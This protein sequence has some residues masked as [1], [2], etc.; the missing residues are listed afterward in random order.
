[1]KPFLLRRKNKLERFSPTNI[2]CECGQ[3]PAP[4]VVLPWASFLCW[5]GDNSPS[6]CTLGS[7]T[8]CV[9]TPKVAEASEVTIMGSFQ[10]ST[11]V[12]FAFSFA[13]GFLGDLRVNVGYLRVVLGVVL[14]AVLLTVLWAVSK[15]VLWAGVRTVLKVVFWALMGW[16]CQQFSSKLRTCKRA[17]TCKH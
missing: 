5:N 9:A 13:V 6:G 8:L 12:V 1:M 2:F 3:A 4:C 17:C 14:L 10:G 16:F 7:T 11:T 15:V